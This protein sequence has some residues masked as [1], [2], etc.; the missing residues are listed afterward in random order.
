MRLGI[1]LAPWSPEHAIK[2]FRAGKVANSLQSRFPLGTLPVALAASVEN[3]ATNEVNMAETGLDIEV[4]LS[5]R[6]DDGPR[7]PQ[8]GADTAEGLSCNE[9]RLDDG[10]KATHRITVEFKGEIV[11][12][13]LAHQPRSIIVVLTTD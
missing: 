2:S 11:S 7:K 4:A 10:P 3:V 1:R 6:F 12:R 9:P 5:V 8:P 13:G